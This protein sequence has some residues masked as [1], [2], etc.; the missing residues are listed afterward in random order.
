LSFIISTA[1]R[2]KDHDLH[3]SQWIFL[4]LAHSPSFFTHILYAYTFSPLQLSTIEFLLGS[5]GVK[6]LFGMLTQP[7]EG[8]WYLED[9]GSI[10][11]L[12]LTRAQTY[13]V[14]FTEGSQVVVQGELADSVFRVQV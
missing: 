7:E 2:A 10:I 4:I 11:R 3:R 13:N 1:A 5:T 12:D 6:V 14:F 8:A 9:L